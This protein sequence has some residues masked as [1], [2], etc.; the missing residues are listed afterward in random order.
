MLEHNHPTPV[1]PQRV[2]ILGA[3]GFVAR[4]LVRHLKGQQIDHR[5]IGSDEI[6]VKRLQDER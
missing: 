3:S 1:K 4:D 6:F 5:A 2:V